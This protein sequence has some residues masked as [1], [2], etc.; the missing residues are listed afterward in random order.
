METKLLIAFIVL[1][2]AVILTT[3]FACRHKAKKFCQFN[4]LDFE[5]YWHDELR[6]K[7]DRESPCWMMRY[8]M[9][10]VFVCLVGAS[11][12]LGGCSSTQYVPVIENH[13]DTLYVSTEKRDSIWL[14][15]SIHVKENGDSVLIE[16]WHTKYIEKLVRD[17]LIH[18]Q[19]DSVPCPYE[20]TKEVKVEKQLTWWQHTIMFMGWTLLVIVAGYIAFGLWK[21]YKKIKP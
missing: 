8:K 11:A 2:L 21:L 17:T 10:F 5:A 18:V 13:P 19:V 15:D 3:Y 1:F 7:V 4:H 14:H 6:G 12:V 20:I 9:L 16:K